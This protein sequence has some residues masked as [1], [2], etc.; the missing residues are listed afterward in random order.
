MPER[1]QKIIARA[2]ITS[3]RKA[4]DL[5]TEGRVTVNGA[6]VRELGSRADPAT[7]AVCVDGSSVQR[8]ETRRYLAM[9]KPK[10][11]ITSTSDPEGRPTVMD[12]LGSEASKGLFPVGR[13]DYNTEGL[14]LLT[15]DG[16]FANRILAA[17][18]KVPKTY[19]VKVSGRPPQAAVQRLREGIK[20]DGRLT[21]P[22]SI[23][24]LKSADNPWFEVTLV[25]GRNRQIHRMFERIGFLVEKIRRVSIGGL[26]LRGL[27]PR[28]VRELQSREVQKLLAP[29][30]VVRPL[31]KGSEPLIRTKPSRN[32]KP[33]SPRGGGSRTARS[34]ERRRG[35]GPERRDAGPSQRTAGG[36]KRSDKPRRPPTQRRPTAERS[37]ARAGT[38]GREGS[39]R[40]SPAQSRA[41]RNSRPG[42]RPRP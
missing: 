28:Q 35:S 18:S 1:L 9:N 31:R 22:E 12:L 8:S 17:K 16:D 20:L 14:L 25:E 36:F 38:T 2:G 15:D 27:E 3:R 13:L 6:V 34:D 39:P 42:S 4:E 21:K 32:R 26:T 29:R 24:M 5:I 33:A 23:R 19:E 40:R 7:D 10:G 37:P 41:Q 11:C 30:P